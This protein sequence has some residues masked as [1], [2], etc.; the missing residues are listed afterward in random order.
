MG[1]PMM[2]VCGGFCAV[3]AVLL[4]FFSS[5]VLA[6]NLNFVLPGLHHK[7]AW[8]LPTKARACRNAGIIYCILACFFFAGSPLLSALRHTAV[9]RWAARCFAHGRY[10]ARRSLCPTVRLRGRKGSDLSD[11]TSDLEEL[12][13]RAWRPV[14]AR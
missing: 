8:D 3:A 12:D 14:I 11:E 5:R 4:F 7:P 6:G 9:G 13:N 1:S 2:V 10:H